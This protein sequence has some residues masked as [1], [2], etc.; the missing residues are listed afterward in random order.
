MSLVLP[1]LA[2]KR[3]EMIHKA[4]Q[5][6]ENGQCKKALKLLAKAEKMEYG[7]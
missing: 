1:S 5:K 3:L 2:Q 6:Y 4:E 7:F